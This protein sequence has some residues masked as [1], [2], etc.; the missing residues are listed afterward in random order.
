MKVQIPYTGGCACGA[1]RYTC[2]AEPMMLRN[3]HCQDCQRATGSAF[4]AILSLPINGFRLDR[5]TTIS[6][7][8]VGDNGNTVTRHSCEACGSLLHGF[9]SAF[10][11]LVSLAVGSLDDPSGFCPDFELFTS[12]AH[13]WA[14]GYPE[15]RKFETM[16]TAEQF[17]ELLAG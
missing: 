12:R 6:N 2:S 3:C 8:T 7:T 1:V 5:G 4:A 13:A 15:S 16:P 17:E 10:P 14:L 9:A 11:D